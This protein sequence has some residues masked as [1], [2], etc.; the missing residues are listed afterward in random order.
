MVKSSHQMLV[1]S[2]GVAYYVL[3]MLDTCKFLECN[4][5]TADHFQSSSE[6]VGTLLRML[7]VQD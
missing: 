7:W 2:C 5:Y 1:S 6:W 3:Q 4:D